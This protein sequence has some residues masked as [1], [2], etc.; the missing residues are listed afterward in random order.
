MGTPVATY[1]VLKGGSDMGKR[2]SEISHPVALFCDWQVFFD[3]EE[4]ELE[5][6]NGVYTEAQCEASGRA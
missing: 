5:E 6:L 4:A 1:V 2:R 3:G